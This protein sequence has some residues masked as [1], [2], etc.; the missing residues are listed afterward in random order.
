MRDDRREHREARLRHLRARALH[1]PR[2]RATLISVL[3]SV[4]IG[5]VCMALGLLLAREVTFQLSLDE[6]S[7]TLDRLA[8]NVHAGRDPSLG[9]ARDDRVQIVDRS[10]RILYASA[11]LRGKPALIT[12]DVAADD[13]LVDDDACPPSLGECVWV[14]GVRI[15]DG[16][17]GRPVVAL[18][19]SHAPTLLTGLLLAV[20]MAAVLVL[21][22]AAIGWWTWRAVGLSF[23]PVEAMRRQI[24][25]INAAAL[26]ARVTVPDTGGEI[27]RLA[28]TVNE[29]LG[30]L[31][32]SASRERRFISDASHDLRNPIAGLHTR[33]EAALDE[34][35]DFDWRAMVRAAVSDTERLNDIVN[36]LLELSRLDGRSPAPEEDVDLAAMVRRE[37]DRRPARVPIT[38]RLDEGAIVVANGLRLA[39]VLGNLL[40]NAERHALSSIEVTVRAEDGTVTMEVLDDGSGVAPENRERVFERFARLPESRRRDPAGTGL[41]LPIA[42]EIAETYGGSLAIEDSP[43]GARFVLRLPLAAHRPAPAPA[44]SS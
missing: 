12:R 39:R 43:R 2:G 38:T 10:G 7:R 42:R 9:E 25:R 3:V 35:D 6:A 8:A 34:D 30:R 32:E 13:V 23:A 15:S 27:Q 21:V 4:G 14:T 33:L 44:P 17:F 18:V 11:E 19:A 5:A 16:T 31:D 41:G 26:G 22:V 20:E 37:I 24:A 29:T 28:E 1:T 36:D 40:A